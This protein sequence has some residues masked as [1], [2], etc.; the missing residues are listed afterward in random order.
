MFKTDSYELVSIN[1]KDMNVFFYG[2]ATVEETIF[3]AKTEFYRLASTKNIILRTF[4][5]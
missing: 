4:I 3:S 2:L 5:Y 1:E